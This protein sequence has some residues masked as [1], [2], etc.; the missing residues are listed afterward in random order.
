MAITDYRPA[1]RRCR[2]LWGGCILLAAATMM[3]TGCG[4]SQTT[5]TPVAQSRPTMPTDT[6]APTSSA[7]KPA[8]EVGGPLRSVGTI[9]QSN[10]EGTGIGSKYRLG[11]LVYGP[12]EIPP[13]LVLEAC[14]A[15]YQTTIAQTGFAR[16]QV[17]VSYTAGSLAQDV[18]LVPG[19]MVVSATKAIPW[20]GTTAFD[21]EG[22]WKCDKTGEEAGINVTF[23]PGETKTFRFWI[24][25]SGL[26]NA[27]PRFTSADTGIWKFNASGVTAGNTRPTAT[28]S[29][30]NAGSCEGEDVLMA[31]A[32]LPF[33]I[34][35]EGFGTEGTMV[36]CKAV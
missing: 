2:H 23:Q 3:L 22:Q 17:A 1:R 36:A 14:S 24:L 25:A 11:P 12:N 13:P 10:S 19:E 30:P 8:P 21:V 31:Y 33:S 34:E 16:G 32:K 29:G 7:A 15:N 9:R 27:H 5:A 4:N 18:E 6:T 28:T 35:V 26:S 20:L